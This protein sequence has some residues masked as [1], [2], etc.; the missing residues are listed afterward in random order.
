MLRIGSST[1]AAS[2]GRSTIPAEIPMRCE[3]VRA[4]IFDMMCLKQE[5]ASGP[6]AAFDEQQFKMLTFARLCRLR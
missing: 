4:C 1:Y 3:S 2:G 6:L 5:F